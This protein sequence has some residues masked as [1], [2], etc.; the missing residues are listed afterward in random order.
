MTFR[1]CLATVFNTCSQALPTMKVAKAAATGVLPD[2]ARPDATP[3]RSCSLIPI[4]M[5]LSG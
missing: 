3:T 4:W 2:T 5:N 1:F